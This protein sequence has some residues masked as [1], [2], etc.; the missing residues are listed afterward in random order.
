MM[1]ALFNIF[2]DYHLLEEKVIIAL[3]VLVLYEEKIRSETVEGE[4][5]G[6][7]LPDV[8]LYFRGSE[9][10]LGSLITADK[11]LTVAHCVT[12]SYIDGFGRTRHKILESSWIAIRLLSDPLRKEFYTWEIAVHP[13]YFRYSEAK[14]SRDVAILTLW[15]KIQE[16]SLVYARI[17]TVLFKNDSLPDKMCSVSVSTSNDS[18]EV[19]RQSVTVEN[20][21]YCDKL[22]YNYVNSDTH[23]CTKDIGSA[24]CVSDSGAGLYCDDD[25]V[26]V[27]SWCWQMGD[28][29]YTVYSRV[30][31][32]YPFLDSTMFSSSLK[33]IPLGQFKLSFVIPLTLRFVLSKYLV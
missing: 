23:L 8:A 21:E 28:A 20:A 3:T 32:M 13:E 15:Y 27:S 12:I 31:N 10:C 5:R 22:P 1:R 4:G 29:N 6:P 24:S 16:P 9:I 18:L 33:N 30:D 2:Q 25:L 7:L 17:H 19:V 26:G 11:V 14:Y